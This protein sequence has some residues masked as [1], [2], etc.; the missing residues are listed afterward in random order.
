MLSD[1]YD[2]MKEIADSKTLLIVGAG[3]IGSTLVD[4]LTPALRRIGINCQ[5]I[6]MDGDLVEA[7]NLGHQRF[8]S[9]DIGLAKVDALAQRHV[10]NGES[11]VTVTAIAEDLRNLE[12]LNDADLVIVCVDRPEPRRLIHQL[13]VPWADLRCGGDG[14]LVMTS[15][16]QN[17]LVEAMTPDHPA[18]SCQHEGAL[19]SGN[20]EF[21]FLNAAAFGAQWALQQLRG[22][23]TPVQS[24]ASITYGQMH[25]PEV[26]E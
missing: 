25:F 6:I 8:T 26:N 11:S 4:V 12:Q 2:C 3:G 5:I 15:N 10:A 21:G 17:A 16:S 1:N 14:H 22:K 13:Q 19:E 9:S 18:K 24:M 23:P 7:T 20:L